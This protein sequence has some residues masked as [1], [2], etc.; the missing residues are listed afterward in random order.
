MR[1]IAND[2]TFHHFIFPVSGSICN[3]ADGS[4]CEVDTIIMCTGY[5]HHYPFLSEELRLKCPN[6]L[7][8]PGLYKGILWSE[9]GDGRLLYIGAQDQY[10]T[11]TMFDAQGLWAAKYIL[12]YIN[13]PGK[14]EMKQDWQQWVER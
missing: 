9:A 10:Y 2:L 4:S 8:P 1:T 6:V 3:F 5:L 11:Y 14:D 7:Y 13:I 12:G